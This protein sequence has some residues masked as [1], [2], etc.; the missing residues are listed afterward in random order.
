MDR[1]QG[2]ALVG[3][4]PLSGCAQ[5][6]VY[7]TRGQSLRIVSLATAVRGAKECSSHGGGGGGSSSSRPLLSVPGNK[8]GVE[9]RRESRPA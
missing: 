3:D 1:R 4:A 9:T 5:Y 8:K 2:P 7:R 6:V